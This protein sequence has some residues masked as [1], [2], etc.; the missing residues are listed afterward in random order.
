MNFMIGEKVVYPNQGV[1]TIENIS[2]RSFGANF[3]RFYLLRLLY[4]SM[5]VM[6]PFSNVASVGL[7]KIT[8]GQEVARVLAFLSSGR[9]HSSSDW[10]CRFKENSDKMQ[11]GSLLQVAEVMKTLL[12]LQSDKPLSFREKKMLDRARHLLVSELSIARGIND[13]EAVSTLEK[14]L[15]KAGLNLPPVL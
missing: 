9:C 15:Q 6:V 7:R 8:K 11:S 2:T 12:L 5:T 13:V 3:E 10:K 1:A 14:A 4:S